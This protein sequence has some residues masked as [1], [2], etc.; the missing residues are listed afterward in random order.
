MSRIVTFYSYK[1]GV[2]RTFAL[3]NIAVLLAKRGRKVLIIDWDL[4]APGLHRY[5]NAEL[6]AQSRPMLGLIYLLTQATE[7]QDARWEPFVEK[8]QLGEGVEIALI[9]SGDQAS[10]Y[11]DRVRPFSWVDFFEKVHGGVVLERWRAEWKKDFDFVLV[12]SRTGIT[13]SGGVCTTLLPDILVLVFSANEQSFE[14][15]MRVA[16]GVQ[17]A[18]QRLDVHRP[19]VAVLPLPCRFDGRD[20]VD[21]AKR[22]LDRFGRELKPFYDDWLPKQFEPRQIL[23]LTKVPYVTKFSFGEPLAVLTHGVTDPEFP[24]FYLENA[25]RLLMTD[26]RDAAQIISPEV[27]ERRL[28]VADFRAQLAKV[29]IDEAAVKQAVDEA[30]KELGTG[31]QLAELLNEAGVALLRQGRFDSAEG[32][33]RRALSLSEFESN[34]PVEISS[35]NYLAELLNLTERQSESEAAYRRVVEI[36]QESL[37][38]D[39][40]S[41]TAA[42]TNLASVLRQSGQLD[43]AEHLYRRAIMNLER[44]PGHNDPALALAY[45]SLAS[46][47]LRLGRVEEAERLYRGA[48][49]VLEGTA[50]PG[51]PIIGRTYHSLAEL[52]RGTNR[53]DEAEHLY[54]RALDR[55]ESTARPG[56]PNIGRTY[57]GLAELLRQ[58]HRPQEAE[59][60]YRRA[61]DRL[62]SAARPGDSTITRIYNSLAELLLKS[63]RMGEAEQ[64]YRQALGRIESTGRP[65]GLPIART[66][67]LLAELLQQSG[68]MEEAEHM[69]RGVLT[70]LESTARPSDPTISRIYK[71]FGELLLR[72]GRS[73][74]AEEVTRRAKTR[75][76]Y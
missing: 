27:A 4:E 9:A 7:N 15:G 59:Q 33:L 16:L 72:S 55:L 13:D 29:S 63:G 24:G 28:G 71:D 17:D 69:Y 67:K 21:E 45:N 39:H 30:E 68:R 1:G 65:F 60:V 48:L 42:Y 18:R 43:E 54:R 31:S 38:E 61:I 19:P 10:D 73:E 11:A 46:V 76:F 23:E 26:F 49:D 2:G 5:F 25:A 14:G 22:W 3:A 52:L 74:E 47:L 57:T 51:D 32:Y 8:L 44:R 66:Y 6:K 12:D 34:H 20:E 53:L 62:G 70:R 35:L 37:G 75:S 50:R 64:V 40:P 56:D 58:S 36:L 41:L